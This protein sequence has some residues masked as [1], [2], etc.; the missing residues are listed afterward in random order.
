[1]ILCALRLV[2]HGQLSA[3][4]RE[5]QVLQH[6]S[7]GSD[8]ESLRVGSR[9]VYGPCK[10]VRTL[11]SVAASVFRQAFIDLRQQSGE[12]FGLLGK[13]PG[14]GLLQLPEV[15]NLPADTGQLV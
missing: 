13:F 12:H 11:R 15:L 5:I 14:V 9:M 3:Q 10:V 6:L 2:R 4:A 8:C 1:M 7:P